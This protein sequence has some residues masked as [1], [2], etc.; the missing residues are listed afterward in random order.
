MGGS[1][2]WWGL[3]PTGGFS[4]APGDCC[5]K[6]GLSGARSLDFPEVEVQIFFR[7][8]KKKETKS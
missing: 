7:G 2:E 4:S 6:C 3:R 1:E 8:G 5:Y